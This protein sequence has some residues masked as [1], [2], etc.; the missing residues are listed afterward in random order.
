MVAVKY[1]GLLGCFVAVSDIDNAKDYQP[2][3]FLGSSCAFFQKRLRD[4]NFKNYVTFYR[5]QET[6][7]FQ[8]VHFLN[9]FAF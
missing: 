4:E 7:H 9:V 8:I 3:R 5:T 1:R 6:K 2:P